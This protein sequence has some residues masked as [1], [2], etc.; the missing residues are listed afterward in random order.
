[1]A[2]LTAFADRAVQVKR[3][4]ITLLLDCRKRGRIAALGSPVR[5]NTL[6]GFL[7]LDAS[8]ID[9][10][11]ERAGSPKIGLFTPGTH[12][13]VADERRL[14]EEQP[15]FVL[16]NSW[17]IGEELMKKMRELGYNGTFIVPLPEPRLVPP[18][19]S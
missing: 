18:S 10:C 3:D 4:L 16:V 1:M 17:H 19:A 5:A 6:M 7:R 13:P 11:A 14:I 8:Y 15:E 9:Y 2:A 12:L